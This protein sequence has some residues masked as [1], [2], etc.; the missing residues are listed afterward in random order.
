MNEKKM[1]KEM[2]IIEKYFNIKNILRG[3]LLK[4]SPLEKQYSNSPL[5]LSS[6]F[7]GIW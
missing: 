3:H 6:I 5:C 4:I 2:C 1:W 7:I